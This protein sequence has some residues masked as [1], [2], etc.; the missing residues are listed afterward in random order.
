MLAKFWWGTKETKM[1]IHWMWWDR[2]GATKDRWG[3]AFRSFCD[4]NQA[5]HGKQYWR[6]LSKNDFI[7]DCCLTNI[8][9][10]KI[11]YNP[12]YAW[13]SLLH[14]RDLVDNGVQWIVSNGRSI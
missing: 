4:F 11:G 2:L 7:G 3:L 1:R 12:I 9:R 10:A 5:L 8:F 6:L 13:R 14:P